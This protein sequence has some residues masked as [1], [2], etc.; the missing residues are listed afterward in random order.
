[1]VEVV[2][3]KDHHTHD[4]KTPEEVLRVMPE[5]QYAAIITIET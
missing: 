3:E 1:M 2:Q 5:V 4:L